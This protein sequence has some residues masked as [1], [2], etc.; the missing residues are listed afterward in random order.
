MKILGKEYDTSLQG[1]LSLIKKYKISLGLI[2]L[3]LVL[4]YGLFTLDYN[5]YHVVITLATFALYFTVL[6]TATSFLIKKKK[7]ILANVSILFILLFITEMA[8]YFYLGMPKKEWKDY[9][10]ANPSDHIGYQLGHVPWADSVW[11]D[12]KIN[13]NDTVFDTYY[14]VDSINRRVTPG[15]DGNK[16]KHAVFF[17]CSISFGYGLK[18][19]QTIPYYLQENTET[20]NSYNYSFNGWGSHHMLAR[21]EHKDLSKEV[22]EKDGIG[23]YIF[24]WPHIRRA[25]GDMRIYT[26]W[27]HTMPYYYL[28]DG[29]VVRDGN[30]ADGRW[31]KSKL[32]EFLKRSFIW[33]CFE[34]NLPTKIREEHLLLAVEIIKKSKETYTKQFGNDKFYVVIHPVDW[35][36]F[37]QEKNNEF[38]LLLEERGINYLDYS[39][40]LSL[41]EKHTIKGDGHP[42][43][44]SDEKCAKMLVKDLG[45]K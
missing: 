3:F 27:G 36:A 8:C 4:K 31:F 22:K 21:L 24:I 42:N 13:G 9:S 7:T 29:E 30:F 33:D 18:G 45:L 37:T 10:T 17:G 28:D 38:K 12:V 25:I 16:D 41:D 34:V 11:H 2:F 32:Y 26:G 43:E 15:H 19:D 1:V 14:D 39:Q 6:V 20:Y 44:I 40:K 35:E 5:K 23:V